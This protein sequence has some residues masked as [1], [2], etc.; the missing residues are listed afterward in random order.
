MKVRDKVSE[1]VKKIHSSVKGAASKIR[2]PKVKGRKPVSPDSIKATNFPMIDLK[3]RHRILAALAYWHILIFLPIA[4]GRKDLFVKY[5]IKQGLVL[6][7]GWALVLFLFWW[8]PLGWLG[9][10]FVLAEA[11][12]GSYNATRGKED[13]LPLIGQYAGL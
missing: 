7:M 13:S 1:H 5:H 3:A 10:L 2:L 4:F 6:L 9:L 11:L 8:P 12:V